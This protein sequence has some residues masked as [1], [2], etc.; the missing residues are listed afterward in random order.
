MGVGLCCAWGLSGLATSKDVTHGSQWLS[1][2]R[3][4]WLAGWFRGDGWFNHRRLH[5]R[6]TPGPSYT[7]PAEFE[8]AHYDQTRPA[9]EAVTQ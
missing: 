5:G 2:V 6:V 7:T 4:G 9:P 1:P 8:A 3:S